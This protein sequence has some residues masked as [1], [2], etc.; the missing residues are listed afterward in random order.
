M[1][2]LQDILNE[3]DSN[4][5]FYETDNSIK[6]KKQQQQWILRRCQRHFSS[7]CTGRTRVWPNL[8]ST[9]LSRRTEQSQDVLAHYNFIFSKNYK[10]FHP[11][12]QMYWRVEL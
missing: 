12:V 5:L 3:S 10:R 1:S 11:E 7:F 2:N 9:C 4:D 8:C 6:E